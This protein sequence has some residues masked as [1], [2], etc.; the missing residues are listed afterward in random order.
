MTKLVAIPTDVIAITDR[1]NVS[2]EIKIPPR[3]ITIKS[4]KKIIIPTFIA[5]ILAIIC[6]NMSAPLTLVLFRSINPMPIPISIP[7][8]M[9]LVIEFNRT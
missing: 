9:E 2:R 5:K 6:A 7:P 4:S 3:A 8:M 1:Y